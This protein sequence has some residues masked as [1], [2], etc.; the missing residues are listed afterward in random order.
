MKPEKIRHQHLFSISNEF[1]NCVYESCVKSI[2][3][4]KH[5][6]ACLKLILNEKI[7][8]VVS[9]L[10]NLNLRRWRVAVASFNAFEL[11]EIENFTNLRIGLRVLKGTF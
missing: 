9:E 5:K 10:L 4:R 2:S 1:T 6:I 7:G 11:F 8:G 3:F